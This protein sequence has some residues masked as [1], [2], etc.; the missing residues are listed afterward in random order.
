MRFD[1]AAHLLAAGHAA[2]SVAAESGY[3][4]Q[5]HLYREVKAF[6]GL[7]RPRP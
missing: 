6:T 5:S 1:H 2:A 4:D 3:V 7:L